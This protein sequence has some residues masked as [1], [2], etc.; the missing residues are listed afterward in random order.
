MAYRPTTL[1]LVVNLLRDMGRGGD[2][3]ILPTT[4]VRDVDNAVDEWYKH[5]P[6]SFTVKEMDI[7]SHGD[8]DQSNKILSKYPIPGA[9]ISASL[10]AIFDWEF[11]ES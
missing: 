5:H 2:I 6:Y 3:S 11:T 7:I 4:L 8:E 9:K 10:N 1:Y